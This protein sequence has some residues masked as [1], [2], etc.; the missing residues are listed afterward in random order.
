MSVINNELT[1]LAALT[2]CV[3]LNARRRSASC[4]VEGVQSDATQ[5]NSTRRPVELCRYKRGFNRA[6]VT[7]K[8]RQFTGRQ[9]T[10][11]TLLIGRRF[12]GRMNEIAQTQRTMSVLCNLTKFVDA[13]KLTDRT[14]QFHWL[15]ATSSCVVYRQ[16][17]TRRSNKLYHTLWFPISFQNLLFTDKLILLG[18]LQFY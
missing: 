7:D 6:T 17:L 13:H 9:L 2:G 1:C 16:K 11:E 4:V 5:L 15:W 12:I 14:S 8:R 10:G 3:P 18:T